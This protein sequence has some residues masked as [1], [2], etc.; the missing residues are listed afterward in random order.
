ME[1]HVHGG[2][3]TMRAVLDALHALPGVRPAEAGEFAMRAF[4]NGKLDL[5]EAEGL[6]DL[7]AAETDAQRRQVGSASMIR[8]DHL[9]CPF[10]RPVAT[11]FEVPSMEVFLLSRLWTRTSDLKHSPSCTCR[12]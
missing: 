6:A 8:S 1:L 5:T 7:V 9:K 12:K 2:P 3:A 4:H 10:M 11:E